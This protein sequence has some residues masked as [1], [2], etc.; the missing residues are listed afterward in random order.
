MQRRVHFNV[1]GNGDIEYNVK[2]RNIMSK[3]HVTPAFNY[4]P[5]F[6]LQYIIP[7]C[8][9]TFAYA[10]L[11]LKLWGARAPGNALEIRDANHMKNKK[12]VRFPPHNVCTK[13][14]KNVYT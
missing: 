8:V 2:F 6:F 13:V 9:I 1:L 5:V 14:A 4:Y 12:K 10:H 3:R 11:A 7:L